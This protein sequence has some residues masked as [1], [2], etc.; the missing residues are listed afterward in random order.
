MAIG[1]CDTV[2]D[3]LTRPSNLRFITP[4]SSTSAYRSPVTIASCHTPSTYVLRPRSSTMPSSRHKTC[5]P[6]ISLETSATSSLE[7]ARVVHSHPPHTAALT[8]LAGSKSV[9]VDP[10][11][12]LIRLQRAVARAHTPTARWHL[13]RRSWRRRRTQKARALAVEVVHLCSAVFGVL[14]DETHVKR[15]NNS[16]I[17]L[18]V[19]WLLEL[20]L[21]AKRNNCDTAVRAE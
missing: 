10:A 2:D 15:L 11:S 18:W 12:A 1:E 19:G 16:C 21:A 6:R 4:W 9:H 17:C 8:H 14:L 7:R 5:A 3:Q 13:Q 20:Y